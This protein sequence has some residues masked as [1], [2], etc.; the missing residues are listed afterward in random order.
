MLDKSFEPAAIEQRWYRRW[1]SAGWFRPRGNATPAYCIQLPPPNVTG[2]LHMGHA[3]QQTLMDALVRYHRM[4][5]DNA[6]WVAGTDHA[7]IATQIVVERQLEQEG[8][9]RHDLGR[10]AFLKR[11]WEWKQASGS[12]IT[13]QMRRLG[14]SCD[15]SNE[16]FTMDAKMSRAVVEVFVSLF[17]QK[18]IYRGKRL[19][20]WDPV[21]GTA[22]SD[23]EVDTEEAV[24]T[25]WQILYPFVDGPQ[26]MG[27]NSSQRVMLRGMTIAT[28]RPET[29]LADGAVAVHPEDPRYRHLVGKR[30]DLPLCDRSIP[31]V[32][33][34]MVEREFGTGC[35]KITGAHDFNDY[36]AALRHQ[37]PMI[38]IFTLDAKINENGPA[39]FRGMDRYVA[40]KAVVAQLERGKFLVKAEPHKMQLPKSGRTGVVVEPMLTDQWFV[41]MD[42]LAKKGLEVV[43]NGQVKF[44]PEH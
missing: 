31:I 29:M 20:N 35:V 43:A 30:V 21:L 41:K 25:M 2:T 42:G 12:T 15:W 34:T 22:V 44:F 18:L 33:D 38:V 40:R 3:F 1:E 19:V 13:R 17:E 10:E 11:A 27:G 4:R 8:K 39:Q 9:S 14:A 6:N 26:P 24:G 32:A 7:G 16:Y 5:G 36:G 23:L 37:L 28:T